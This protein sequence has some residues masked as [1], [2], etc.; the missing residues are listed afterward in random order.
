M[1]GVP[2]QP[3]DVNDLRTWCRVSESLV[4]DPEYTCELPLRHDGG[5]PCDGGATCDEFGAA[6]AVIGDK[7][8][9][10]TF[11]V[12]ETPTNAWNDADLISPLKKAVKHF[13]EEDDIKAITCNV[14]FCAELQPMV[15]N[16]TA[17]IQQ[18]PSSTAKL[19]PMLLGSPALLPVFTGVFRATGEDHDKLLLQP[20]ERILIIT[21]YYPALDTTQ[22]DAI[23][24]DVGIRS[25]VPIPTAT[26]LEHARLLIE[27]YF[28]IKALPGQGDAA[29]S[30]LRQLYRLY[31]SSKPDEL[32]SLLYLANRTV[33]IGWN[34]M[35]GYIPV[36]QG[37]GFHNVNLTLSNYYSL[38]ND[39]IANIT[40]D[41]FTL[42]A[43]L[44]ASCS[45][46]QLGPAQDDDSSAFS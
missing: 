15:L 31:D 21:S 26:D 30:I 39:T 19:K 40:R 13:L 38:V 41:G 33:V 29:L 32:N 34:D 4:D 11:H 12:S 46:C 2:A 35:A 44:C 23:I 7:D 14:G 18:D 28:G 10:F 22:L 6:Y 9:Q 43:R 17:S 5:T 16:V 24:Q 36:D 25:N 42:K 27:Q 37:G 1:S 3:G 8:G 20:D 45:C